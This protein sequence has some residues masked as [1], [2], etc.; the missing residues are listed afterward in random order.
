MYFTDFFAFL[1]THCHGVGGLAGVFER[2]LGNEKAGARCLS[3]S[4]ICIWGEASKGK[5]FGSF[6][7][8]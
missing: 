8:L 1:Y 7:N 6:L 3:V 5:E 4:L 2:I